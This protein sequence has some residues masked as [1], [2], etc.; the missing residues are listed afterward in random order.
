MKYKNI[1]RAIKIK[2]EF[3]KYINIINGRKE[4]ERNIDLRSI[5]FLL[6]SHNID[7][8][9]EFLPKYLEL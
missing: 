1:E 4:E 8:V 7:M 6:E 5:E 9:Y 3:I 2:P